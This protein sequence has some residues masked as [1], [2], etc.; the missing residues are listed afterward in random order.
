MQAKVCVITGA[1]SGIGFECAKALAS[2]RAHVVLVC[3]DEN[4][5]HEACRAISNTVPEAQVDLITGNLGS[6]DG[7]K[8]LAAQLLASYPEIHVLINNAGVWMTQK[9]I[10]KDGLELSFMVNHLAPFM[11]IHLLQPALINGTPARIINISA[12]LYAKG[13]VD[14][15]R[16]PIGA[17][18]GRLK[19]Y[20]N[21]KLCNVLTLAE[22]ARRLKGTG[23]TLNFVH[24]GVVNTKLGD[25]KGFW[26]WL[27]RKVKQ[28]WLTPEQG[29]AAPIW[30]ATA[31]E[32]ADISGSYFDEKEP[33]PLAPNALNE[34]LARQVWDISL[35]LGHINH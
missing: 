24:P 8:K 7:V 18:F 10:T 26:G 1:N 3:R 25:S 19:T 32:M 9:R 17:D 16:T 33:V 4:R 6:I 13:A 12:G 14:I 11:L 22:A 27:L 35:E 20:A 23:V 2:L 21:S 31:P 15:E 30:L 34:K 28:S 29:A 5:G